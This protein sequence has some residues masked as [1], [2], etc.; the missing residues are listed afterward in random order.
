MR[1]QIRGWLVRQPELRWLVLPPPFSIPR[2]RRFPCSPDM[3]QTP[4]VLPPPASPDTASDKK[5]A[6]ATGARVWAALGSLPG[7]PAGTSSPATGEVQS[8]DGEEA[9][10]P[11]DGEKVAVPKAA[12]KR[13]RQPA[14][15]GGKRRRFTAAQRRLQKEERCLKEAQQTKQVVQKAALEAAARLAQLEVDQK[16]LGIQVTQARVAHKNAAKVDT[17]NAADVARVEANLIRQRALLKCAQKALEEDETKNA[18]LAGAL[19]RASALPARQHLDAIKEAA[20]GDPELNLDFN[21]SAFPPEERDAR[22]AENSGVIRELVQQLR[23]AKNHRLG[24]HMLTD[25]FPGWDGKRSPT[26]ADDF[27]K[28]RMALAVWLASRV[29]ELGKVLDRVGAAEA[30]EIRNLLLL[31]PAE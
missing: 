24:G 4:P 17:K 25:L 28:L 23:V 27:G 6:A 21:K 26:G 14:G 1:R 11:K 15:G 8:K 5:L 2:P 22:E 30:A 10:A 9:A 3:P 20:R 31:S 19:G 12:G 13:G 29:E 7:E 18:A 16:R